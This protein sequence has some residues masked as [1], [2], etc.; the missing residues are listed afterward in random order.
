MLNKSFAE[1][2]AVDVSRYV[3]KRD[4]QDYLPWTACKQ[5]LHDQ[6]AEV[7]WFEPVVGDNGSSLIMSDREFCTGSD[8][9]QRVNCCYEVRIRI[10]V[11]GELWES[12]FPLMNGANPVQDNSMHQGRIR[13]AQ[14]R[15]F[16]K[17]VAERL[18][19]GW[20]LWL[21]ED[22]FQQEEDLS[23]HDIHKIKER[24]QMLYTSHLRVGADARSIAEALDM[25]VDEVKIIFTYFD[26]LDRFERKLA[27]LKWDDDN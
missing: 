10:K 22:D 7:V 1:L 23:K 27:N 12:Q 20:S 13:T 18:G 2:A 9:S 6:G 26:Q 14:C 11:D 24:V 17:G 16:V 8:K 4:G 15:A 3:K 5:L 25:S 21:N 19:L